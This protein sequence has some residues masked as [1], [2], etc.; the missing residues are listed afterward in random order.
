MFPNF[1]FQQNCKK[2]CFL[3]SWFIYFYCSHRTSRCYYKLKIMR[4]C[5]EARSWKKWAWPTFPVTCSTSKESCHTVASALATCAEYT[6]K[7]GFFNSSLCEH[8]TFLLNF[9]YV[10]SP[11]TVSVC[12]AQGLTGTGPMFLSAAWKVT[13]ESLQSVSIFSG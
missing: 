6:L 5:C 7:H 11:V 8:Q 3:S 2:T 9:H 10:Y 13:R 12:V 4:G 1:S